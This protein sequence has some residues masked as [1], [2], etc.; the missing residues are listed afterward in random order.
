MV[1]RWSYRIHGVADAAAMKEP[2]LFWAGDNLRGLAHLREEGV[3]VDLVY[4]DPPYA[5]GREFRMNAER[6]ST[7]SASA[8]GS[9]AYS[10]KL[11]GEAYLELLENQLVAIR[12]VM[13]PSA[14]I[15]VHI[16][17][18]VEHKV[19]IIM[20]GVFGERNFRNSIVRIKSGPQNF[21]HRR[22]FGNIRDAI[23]FYTCSR[24][25][26]TWNPQ[27]IPYTEIEL[28]RLYPRIDDE[29]RRYTY[30]SLS[31]PGMASGATGKAWRGVLPPEGRSWSILPE[32][33]DA[34]DASGRIAWSKAGNP[35]KIVYSD[36]IGGRLPQDI[37]DYK[38]PPRPDY[39]TQKNSE[40]L[41]RII[42]ASSNE[43]DI[44]MDCFAGSGETL[45]QAYNLG[46]RFIGMDSGEWSQ[47]VI[48]DRL[49][50]FAADLGT[51]TI[52]HNELTEYTGLQ[53]RLL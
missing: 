50:V 8:S 16:G 53:K 21:S 39:P 11:K 38:D 10:D 48:S 44:V 5:T 52:G 2:N 22:S 18:G 17:L 1:I 20:D 7:L 19:R 37:W 31:A 32:A 46:R 9:V 30:H 13:Q 15:Y 35:S 4:I 14:S 12:D 29:G 49:N 6:A 34:L 33:L 25:G 40:M 3:R 41:R 27:R 47:K 28:E 24:E 23:P 45:V 36:E 51:K 43:D 26:T 42:L